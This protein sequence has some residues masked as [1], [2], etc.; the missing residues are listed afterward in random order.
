L[1]YKRLV[2]SLSRHRAAA[3]IVL[4]ALVCLTL[5]ATAPAAEGKARVYIFWGRGCPYC[6]AEKAFLSDLQKRHPEVEIRDYEVWYDLE[7]ARLLARVLKAFGVEP[8]GVPVTVVGGRMW[9][10]FSRATGPLIERE[11]LRCL[12]EGCPGLED[13]ISAPAE[14]EE[15]P[16]TVP[17]VG[18]LEPSRF[19]L[20]V[21]TVI[22]GGLDSFNPCAF[23]V[24]LFLLSLLVHA[25]SRG[26]MALIGG[27]FVFFSGLVYFLFMSAW[28]NVFLMA[29]R[30][31]LITTAA[32][33]VALIMAT[34]NI[35]DFFAFKRGVS[36]TISEGAMKKLSRRMRGLLESASVPSAMAG[37]VALALA[38]NTYE[39]LCTAGFP[40]VFTRVLT[41]HDLSTWQYYAYIA[42][43]NVIYVVPLSAIVVVFVVTLGARKLSR[44]QGR[45]L[46]LVSGLM[47]LSLGLTLLIAPS[48]L[49]NALSAVAMLASALLASAAVVAVSKRLRPGLRDA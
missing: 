46:K 42:L 6:E 5:P 23:F 30:V 28:L 18:K 25:R 13:A 20:P 41:L 38:A 14:P 31:A 24:L 16:L 44:W 48:A 36:L 29:G 33:A 21:L 1:V 39:L 26:R 32:G 22:L 40:M 7:N 4:A 37:A 19:S 34:I 11:V 15:P 10:G 12:S 27:A 35:K 9:V 2:R 45:K 17:L 49:N 43:Y 8:T 3:L 47:M